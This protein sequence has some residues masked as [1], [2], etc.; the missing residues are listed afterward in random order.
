MGAGLCQE[1]GDLE[2]GLCWLGDGESR[3]RRPPSFLAGVTGAW[4][5]LGSLGPHTTPHHG[6][7]AIDHGRSNSKRD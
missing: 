1:V 5:G 6:A 7:Y 3:E 2:I 4:P